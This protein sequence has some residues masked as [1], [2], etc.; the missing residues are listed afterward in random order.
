[1]SN[2]RLDNVFAN[3]IVKMEQQGNEW[4]MT[5]YDV[6]VT[7]EQPNEFGVLTSFNTE[8]A[9]C[10]VV[11]DYASKGEAYAAML[12]LDNADW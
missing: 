10:V 8:H 3:Y 9:E 6:V 2:S 4:E 5:T 7:D 1:M 12:E 11:N